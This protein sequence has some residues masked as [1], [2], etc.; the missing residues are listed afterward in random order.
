MGTHKKNQQTVEAVREVARET[1]L[2][3]KWKQLANVLNDRG[4]KTVNDRT[5]TED[6]LRH[7]CSRHADI[8]DDPQSL[9]QEP[10]VRQLSLEEAQSCSDLEASLDVTHRG[11]PP[12]GLDEGTVNE[13]LSMLAWWRA[14]KDQPSLT[15][16]PIQERPT[17]KRGADTITKTIRIGKALF[18][19]AQRLAKKQRALT[20]GT[21]SGLVELL[22][23][24]RLGCDNKYLRKEE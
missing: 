23:W 17:F 6:S 9:P 8:F 3:R 21:F 16:V 11:T 7:F 24:E 22:L 10:S 20:G 5:W 12:T 13:L 15:S 19:D 2:A 4:I 14:Q 18:Q 1:G